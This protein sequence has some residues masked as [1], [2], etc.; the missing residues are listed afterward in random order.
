MNFKICLNALS[1]GLCVLLVG[2]GG[3][4]SSR[5]PFRGQGLYCSKADIHIDLDSKPIESDQN[6]TKIEF[7]G[8]DEGDSSSFPAGTYTLKSAALL[9]N[10]DVNDVR[11][12]SRFFPLTDKNKN[13]RKGRGGQNIGEFEARSECARGLKP[14][15]AVERHAYAIAGFNIP[16]KGPEDVDV[17]KITF[18]FDGINPWTATFAPVDLTTVSLKQ[19]FQQNADGF[20]AFKNKTDENGKSQ[21]EIRTKLQDGKEWVSA[22]VK[23]EFTA[24]PA[25]TEKEPVEKESSY[26]VEEPADLG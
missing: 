24:A 6:L 8:G 11:F 23:F 5:N 14:G 22:E 21:V 26:K 25:P 19:F 2:C 1:I 18:K 12:F 17:R 10:D 4:G 7:K 16:I 9:Y 3:T 15:V 13:S 20:L